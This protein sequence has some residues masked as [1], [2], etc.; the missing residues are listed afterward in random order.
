MI[1]F[2]T[3]FPS[4]GPGADVYSLQGDAVNKYVDFGNNFAFA[5]TDAFS[6]EIWYNRQTNS[7]SLYP[8]FS[9]RNAAQ[10]R[11]YYFAAR[12]SI[13]QWVVQMLDDA[14]GTIDV[15]G[16]FTWSA[17]TWYQVVFVY[18]G[19][20][21]NTGVTIYINGS[22]Q[23][24][25]SST[26]TLSGSMVTTDPFCIF[27]DGSASVYTA[28]LM[29][30]LRIWNLALSAGNVTTTYG[31]GH[32]IRTGVPQ[33]GNVQGFYPLGTPVEW[34]DSTS[35]INPAV[36]TVVGTGNNFSSGDWV[37]DVP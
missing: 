27:K 13:N 9:K 6:V 15:R 4:S 2:L 32:P 34:T 26:G 29:D 12:P 30:Y 28:G 7:A 11:G 18:T 36:G 10:T 24:T 1:R 3:P 37:T 8:L 5:R 22:A 31:S 14:A 21:S 33:S 25:T 19:N 17:S 23:S 16:S 35:V 20:S